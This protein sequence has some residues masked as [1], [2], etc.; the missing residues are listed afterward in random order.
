MLESCEARMAKKDATASVTIAKKMA[1][2]RREKRPTRKDRA[3]DNNTVTADSEEHGVGKRHDTCVTEEQV[4][5]RNQDHKYAH[6]RRNI[7][8]TRPG[9]KERRK[10][11]CKQDRGQAYRQD[12][13]ARRIAGE[14]GIEQLHCLL[15]G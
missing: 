11:Q 1:F 10:R 7:E 6:L 3:R 2:T 13:A 15:T 14:H 5:A 12:S 9:K 4:V 8:R